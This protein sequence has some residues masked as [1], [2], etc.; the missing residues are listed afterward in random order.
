MKKV[1]ISNLRWLAEFE[2]QPLSEER[3]VAVER[4]Y[5]LRETINTNFD[6]V[7]SLADG[8]LFE[9]GPTC[10]QYLTLRR[11]IR[12]WQPQLRMLFLTRITLFKYRLQLN[13]FEL[14]APVLASQLEFDTRLAGML[15]RMADRMERKAP[16]E[17]H[18]FKDAFERL[19]RV[20]RTCCLQGLQQSIAN[21]LKTFLALS[22]AAQGLVMCLSNEI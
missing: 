12:K 1:F 18:D 13:G 3:K 16:M 11:K 5:F 15:D 10:Q 17:D 21:E 14:P 20:V 9:F 4:S 6:K 19:E 7:R 8:I 22:R 2:R